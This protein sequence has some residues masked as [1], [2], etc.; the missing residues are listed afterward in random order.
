M[1]ITLGVAG[2]VTND[3]VI[4]GLVVAGTGWTYGDWRH[5]PA[6]LAND[7]IMRITS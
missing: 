5:G 2:S 6:S 4:D 7:V 1:S 3:V